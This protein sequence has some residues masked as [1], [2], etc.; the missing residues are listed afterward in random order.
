[1]VA[2]SLL[3][4]L[5]E[6]DVP[7]T[8]PG[9]KSPFLTYDSGRQVWILM[10]ALRN[11]VRYEAYDTNW[12]RRFEIE[13]AIALESLHD[14]ML[15]SRGGPGDQEGLLKFLRQ[16]PYSG[17]IHENAKSQGSLAPREADF[18]V[19]SHDRKPIL[20]VES[21]R[22]TKSRI[23]E[24]QR[25]RWVEQL[26]ITARIF[27]APYAL[28]DI[29][30]NR[31]WFRVDPDTGLRELPDDDEIINTFKNGSPGSSNDKDN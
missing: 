25:H 29:M 16:R 4:E 26:W 1:M 30:G 6:R 12:N 17:L 13:K 23:S 21:K 2:C 24:L 19:L 15:G 14:A 27:M 10:R 9:E 28:L 31:H 11:D 8:G 3:R 5:I 18:L 22:S 7:K 20:V